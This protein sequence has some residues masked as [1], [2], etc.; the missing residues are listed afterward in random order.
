MVRRRLGLF[1]VLAAVGIAIGV[2]F[3]PGGPPRR[4]AVRHA[5]SINLIATP[6]T[7]FVAGGTCSLHPCVEFVAAASSRGP[8]A[9]C[10]AYPNPRGQMVFVRP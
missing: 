1:L 6:G 2:T 5:P 7:C 4:A 9:R 8:S 3:A 10:T